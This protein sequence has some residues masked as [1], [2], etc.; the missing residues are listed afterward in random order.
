[1]VRGRTLSRRKGASKPR[2]WS[3]AAG[4][5]RSFLVFKSVLAGEVG[6]CWWCGAAGRC[7]CRGNTL[8]WSWPV[9]GTCC[10][11]VLSDMSKVSLLTELRGRYKKVLVL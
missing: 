9:G 4:N 3:F 8:A 11:T 2:Q 10:F 7:P 5:T 1:M 6:P